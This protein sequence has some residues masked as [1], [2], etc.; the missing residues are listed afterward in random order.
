MFCHCLR[1]HPNFAERRHFLK[2]K[3]TGDAVG[4]NPRRCL[5]MGQALWQCCPVWEW[6][7]W[8]SQ[9]IPRKAH[10]PGDS[11]FVL[12]LSQMMGLPERCQWT[13]LYSRV[14]QLRTEICTE[15]GVWRPWCRQSGWALPRA[16]QGRATGRGRCSV[17]KHQG[18]HRKPTEQM[19][20]AGQIKRSI[21]F[22]GFSGSRG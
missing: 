12:F 4:Q 7:G 8:D 22:Q 2:V 16:G 20:G 11:S 19:A 3:H 17:I 6:Q 15:C 14:G 10:P 9:L 18:L 5:V 1:K 13:L 21:S